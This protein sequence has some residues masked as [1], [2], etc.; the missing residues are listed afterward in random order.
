[1]LFKP[2]WDICHIECRLFVVTLRMV[3]IIKI[4]AWSLVIGLFLIVVV[5]C[6]ILFYFGGDSSKNLERLHRKTIQ[7]EVVA[8]IN[9][10]IG[11]TGQ[12]P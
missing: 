8:K 3:R 2:V 12:S 9:E 5:C 7:K 4:V 1:M 6:L 11:K 10:Y